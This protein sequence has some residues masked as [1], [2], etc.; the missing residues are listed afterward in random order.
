MIYKTRG[1]S[2]TPSHSIY[3]ELYGHGPQKLLL[4]MGLAGGHTVF[5]PQF[6]PLGNDP[7]FTVSS[8]LYYGLGLGLEMGLR[9]VV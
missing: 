6:V 1:H 5:E 7:R 8:G 9:L 3:Y 4:I 2:R